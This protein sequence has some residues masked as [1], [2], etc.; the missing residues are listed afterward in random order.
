M[1]KDW[2]LREYDRE[3]FERELRSFVPEKIFDAHAHLYETWHWGSGERVLQGPKV[4]TLAEYRRLMEWITP[5]SHTTALFFGTGFSD[6]RF[7]QANE[8]VAAQ[9]S[10]DPECRGEMLVSPRMDP[11]EV[12]QE[13]KR[14]GFTGLKVYHSFVQGEVTWHA[15]ISKFLTEDHV[16]VAHQE[17]WTITLHMVKDRAMADPANQQRIVEYCTR[18]PDMKLILA[19][20]ARGFNPYHTV[21][22]IH[23]LKGLG[24]VWCDT[25][26]VTEAGAFEAIVDTLG[27][28]RLLWGSDFPVSHGRGRCVAIGDQFVWLGEDSLDWDSVAAQAPIQP[29][30]TGLES[31]RVLKLAARHLRLS[32]SQ[33]E[34]IFY[35]NARRMLGMEG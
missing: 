25:S 26:A 30:L 16:R 17:G 4:A 9:V 13:A 18:Y 22:G 14:L 35:Y 12:R 32:D 24:N 33:V 5:G 10:L 11:E 3:L 31:L 29:V 15:D 6:E 23:A 1:K 19:H 8:F 2:E 34:D 28:D 7:R 27:H 21:E 20:A